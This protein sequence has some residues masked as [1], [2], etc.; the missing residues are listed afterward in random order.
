LF[1]QITNTTDDK[2]CSALAKAKH[3][4]PEIIGLLHSAYHDGY[5]LADGVTAERITEARRYA[6]KLLVAVLAAEQAIAPA[7]PA[8]LAN[9]AMEPF[10]GGGAYSA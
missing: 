3:I 6:E 2:L 9:D 8:G 4:G 1:I 7:A 5:R 10:P